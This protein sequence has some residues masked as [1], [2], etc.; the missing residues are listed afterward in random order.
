MDIG[1][2]HD[3]PDQRAGMDGLDAFQYPTCACPEI[4]RTKPVDS[5]LNID[6]ESRSGASTVET[7]VCYNC[8][9]ETTVSDVTTQGQ[10]VTTY[11]PRW[12]QRVN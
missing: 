11:D 12:L 8:A 10:R 6:L 7:Q 2:A 3:A 9:P 5:S 1:D 4:G